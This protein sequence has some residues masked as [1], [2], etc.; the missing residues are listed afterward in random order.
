MAQKNTLFNYFTKSPAHS[1]VQSRGEVVSP[2]EANHKIV[3]NSNAGTPTSAKKKVSKKL[4]PKTDTKK[5]TK[6]ATPVAERNKLT[7]GEGNWVISTFS[8]VDSIN[9]TY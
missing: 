9:V 6:T 1:K 2:S 5:S 4:A 7:E 3:Q 8:D